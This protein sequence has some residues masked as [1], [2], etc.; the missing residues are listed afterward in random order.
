MVLADFARHF[1]TFEPSAPGSL[2]SVSVDDVQAFLSHPSVKPKT[3]AKALKDVSKKMG[4][5]MAAPATKKGIFPRESYELIL[6]LQEGSMADVGEAFAD[7]VAA[8]D[9]A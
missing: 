2:G 3:A 7:H 4:L 5:N 8:T 6:N 1:A 9:C